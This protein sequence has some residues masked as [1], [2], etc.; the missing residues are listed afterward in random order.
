[1]CR[2]QIS[3]M[4]EYF[5]HM[6]DLLLILRY[7]LDV[8]YRIR[9]HFAF[10][11]FKRDFRSRFPDRR[12]YPSSIFDLEK[13]S[14]GR[15]SYG[16]LNVQMLK[17]PDQR[18]IIG[19]F[20]SIAPEVLFILGGNHRHDTVS[21]FPFAEFVL[22]N[23][24]LEIP[25]LTKG[26]IIVKNDVWIGT[27]ATIMSGVTIEQGSIVAAGSLVTRD[28]PPYAIVGG[29][30]AKVIKY[31]FDEKTIQVLLDVVDY[32]RLSD[33]MVGPHLNLLNRPVNTAL[34][35]IKSLFQ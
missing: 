21:T 30:P 8:Y 12:L 18:L 7:L 35:E 9:N 23:S 26:P 22:N 32:A 24:A 5:I 28:V 3:A 4:H 16:P 29:N 13:I 15:H 10:F 14:I 27:R 17:N 34:D 25:E 20:V 6:D 1:M 11:R 2:P 31:R 19:D 33:E